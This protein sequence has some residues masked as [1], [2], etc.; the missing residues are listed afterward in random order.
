MTTRLAEPLE[1]PEIVEKRQKTEESENS[2]SY[3]ADQQGTSKG[4]SP[5]EKTVEADPDD[6]F[7]SKLAEYEEMFKDRYT[8]NDPDYL[9][10]VNQQLEPIVMPNWNPPRQFYRRNG[11]NWR[12]NGNPRGGGRDNYQRNW[13]Q[14]RGN[15][16]GRGYGRDFHD[17]RR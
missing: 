13:D 7:V 9:Y 3:G 2:K 8:E 1:T 12:G 5:D 6:G 15:H 4:N 10:R 17:R 16:S 11:N 14:N